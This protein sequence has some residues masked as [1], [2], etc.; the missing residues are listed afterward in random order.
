MKTF[1]LTF[2]I[3]LSA[4]AQRPALTGTYR[5]DATHSKAVSFNKTTH[6]TGSVEINPEFSA[7]KLTVD[8]DDIS[9][10]STEFVGKLESFEV[11]GLLTQNGV[12]SVVTLRGR[13]FGM[14]DNELGKKAAFNF[15]NQDLNLKILAAKPSDT[16]T[17]LYKEVQSIVE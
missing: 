9:F 3:S 1:L 7:S 10:E 14:I 5:L 17:A 13:Y 2:L 4:V 15:Y 11:K 8:S 12:S 6:I 16:T